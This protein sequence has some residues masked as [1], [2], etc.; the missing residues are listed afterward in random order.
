M[1]ISIYQ[2]YY[3]NVSLQKLLPGFI[4]L[5]NTR[6]ENP[7]WFEFWPILQFL[8][9]NTLKEG[10]WYGFLSPKFYEK[11]GFNSEFVINLLNRYGEAANVALFSFGWDQLAY[12]L[13]PWE[14]GEVWHP[15]VLSSSQNYINNAGFKTD[16]KTL[17]TD[18][19]TSVFSNYI[20]AKRD[21]WLEWRNMAES[22]YNYCEKNPLDSIKTSYGN[23]DNQYPMKAF[24]QERLAT[25]ILATGKYIVLS[26]D[27]SFNGPIFTGLFSSDI[28]NRRLLQTCDL[29]KR[30]FR[31]KSDEKYLEMYWKIRRDISFSNHAV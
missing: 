16:L 11:T 23:V 9:K 14:Q 31:E 7:D 10:S 12:F 3:D 13:N 30:K 22:F 19:T 4:P 2:I 27:Q 1:Q 26:P 18:T 25:L 29:M 28:T 17:V 8:R 21:F 5:D 15:G 20:I 6:S 24:M